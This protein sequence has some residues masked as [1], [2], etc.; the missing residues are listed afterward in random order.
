MRTFRLI[1]RAVCATTVGF[2]V[3]AL[4]W[5][6]EGHTVIA[7]VATES[8]NTQAAADLQWIISVG[9]P[10][11][12]AQIQQ[13]YGAKCQI[14]SSDPWGEVPD[15]RTDHD[16]H[17]NLANWADCYRYLDASTKGWHYNDIPLGE[18]PAGI[19]NANGQKWCTGPESCASVALADNLHKLA[20]PGQ[21]PADLAKALAFV[22][23]IVGDMHQPLHEEDNGDTGGNDVLVISD[24]SGLSAQKLHELWDTPLVDLGLGRN[25]G[26]ATRTIAQKTASQSVPHLTTVDEVILASDAWVE[27]AHQLAQP[28]YSLLNVA[29]GA[30]KVSGVRVTKEYVKT[31]MPIAVSQL[32]LAAV[33][34]RAT[35]NAALKWRPPS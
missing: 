12:N 3:P 10:A 24:D 18:N 20:V 11:L 6:P 4:A 32:G 19:L 9:V 2:S 21:S 31:E 22:V 29:V 15:Y 27:D 5:G 16:Q 7:R 23:H 33:R 34:L 14:N 35:L 30:G 28:A 8:L 26:S 25:L 13:K 1:A 17:T